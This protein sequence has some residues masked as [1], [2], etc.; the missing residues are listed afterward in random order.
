MEL[1]VIT[2]RPRGKAHPVPLL[3]VHG[4]VHGAWCWDEQFLPYFAKQG[5]YASAVS[6]RGHGKSPNDRAL[7]LT[8]TT[9]Y[10]QDVKQA[11]DAL[12]AETG[13]R[14]VIIG[15]SMGG[16]I[17]QKY[18]EQ[19]EAPAGVLLASVPTHGAILATLRTMAHQPLTFLKI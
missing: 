8:R 18:M 12:E 11:A 17:T 7:R 14:P 1:E 6:L 19:Y 5:Y 16:L 15:H 2:R 4:I 3:C 13:R 10:V 9:H